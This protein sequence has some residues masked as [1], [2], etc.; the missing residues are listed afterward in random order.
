MKILLRYSLHL[1]IALFALLIA[2]LNP[3]I[4]FPR[5]IHNYVFVI[6]ITQSMNVL[7]M[8]VGDLPASRLAY[9][10]HLLGTSIG[11]LPC[12][13]KISAALF[14]NAEVVPLFNPIEVCA[15]YGVL[16]DILVNLEWRM[17]WRG[18]SHLRLGLQAAAMTL[19]TL[20]EPAQMV[21]FTDGDEAAPLNVIT[22]TELTALPGSS[23]WLL[24]GVGDQRPSPIPKLNAKNEIIGY[25]SL[26]ATKIEPSQIVN[27]DSLGKR[28][29]SI[30]SDPHEYYLSSLKEDYLKELA[31]DIG[32]AYV[33][34]DSQENLLMA[35][36]GL[37]PAGHDTV[38]VALGWLF[39]LLA[40]VFV[41][42]EYLPVK[43]NI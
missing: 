14:A 23:G 24:A 28:D 42:L 26:Y 4:G 41:A 34:A 10:Q 27:E 11:K 3:K 5:D 36:A 21:F 29:D 15:N 25:W 35:L 17:A 12:G 33:R 16:Q 19:T 8:Q 30:A 2:G 22:K 20:P 18:S 43:D 6:D 38:P 39:A 37:P 40:G 1:W 31:H 13:T 32:A 9:T 7:D